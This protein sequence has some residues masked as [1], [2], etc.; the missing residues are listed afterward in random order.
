MNPYETT[1]LYVNGELFVHVTPD[2]FSD[3]VSRYMGSEAK[4][5][6]DDLIADLIQRCMAQGGDE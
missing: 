2:T 6:F 3:L 5:Y 1:H 4:A